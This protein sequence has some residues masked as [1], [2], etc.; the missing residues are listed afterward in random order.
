[1][2]N[3]IAARW[4][5]VRGV[6]EERRAVRDFDPADVDDNDLHEILDAALLAPTS[7]NLQLFRFHVVRSAE[8]RALV[9][10]ACLGQR[11]ARGAPVLIA[12][13]AC[14]HEGT[15][16]VEGQSVAIDEDAAMTARERDHARS[17]LATMRTVVRFSPLAIARPIL[18]AVLAAVRRFKPTPDLPAGPEAFEG[19]AM[20][21]SAFAAQTLLIAAQAR[22]Y[23]TCP[24]EGFD[25]FLVQ[26]AL[27]LV[28]ERVWL[29]IALGRRAPDAHVPARWR[30]PFPVL[31]RAH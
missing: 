19:W 29:V 21:N 20:R 12:V 13:A 24:M 26:E 15:I 7:S 1:M 14:P 10:E 30:R 2:E 8:K 17:H 11:A 31:V 18:R 25:R 16:S 27:G 5:V 22:G 9:S 23:A 4:A 3:E 28:S 6:I